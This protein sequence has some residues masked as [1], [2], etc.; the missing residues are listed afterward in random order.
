MAFGCNCDDVV[1]V[2]VLLHKYLR[3]FGRAL[4]MVGWFRCGFRSVGHGR[5][6]LHWGM[7]LHCLNMVLVELGSVSGGIRGSVRKGGKGGGLI[8]ASNIFPER[9]PPSLAKLASKSSWISHLSA[10][11]PQAYRTTQHKRGRLTPNRPCAIS[12]RK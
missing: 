11:Q 10:A 9:M 6:W 2:L 4:G 3:M 5:T 12:N 7:S 8:V 1:P